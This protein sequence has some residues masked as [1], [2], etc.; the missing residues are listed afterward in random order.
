MKEIAKVSLQNEMDL[1]LSHRRS[2]KLA[3]LAGLS[4]SAQTT[5]AT[6]VSEVARDVIDNGIN[7]YLVL[8]IYTATPQKSVAA[9]IYDSRTNLSLQAPA[10]QNARKLVNR[11]QYTGTPEA[12]CI[13]MYYH[14]PTVVRQLDQK[15][16]EWQEQFN[17]DAPISPYDEIKRKNEQLQELADRLKASENQYRVLTNALPLIIFT[18]NRKGSIVYA[19]NWMHTY[20]GFTPDQINTANWKQ[21]LHPED[22]SS[23]YSLLGD[24]VT[25][26]AGNLK[27]QCRIREAHSGSYIWH[28]VFVAPLQEVHRPDDYFIGYIV[29]IHAQKEFEQASRDN[30]ELKATQQRLKE[31]ELEL[32][33][34]IHQLNRSNNDLEQFAYI[35]SHDLQEPVRKMIFYSDYFSKQYAHLTDNKG[36]IYLENMLQASHRMRNLINDLLSYSKIRKEVTSFE[37][38]SLQK[39]AGIALQDLELTIK[40]KQAKVTVDVLPVIEGDFSQL[41]QVFQNIV[42]NALK[43]SK[44]QEP[45]QLHIYPETDNTGMVHLHFKDNGIGF[46]TRYLPKMFT[47]FQ[48]LHG[49]DEYEGTGFGLAIC[50]KIVDLHNGVIDAVSEPGKGADFIVSLPET[51]N[52]KQ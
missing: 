14:L 12:S 41:T 38:V 4:L 49:K 28:Q 40:E 1:I 17:Y 7:G 15:I 2:M 43:Y 11:F 52:K 22:Y 19:N 47:L 35:A 51:Q 44:E 16:T 33:Q 39:A 13:E 42:S 23:F 45:L 29:D 24:I 8:G 6:A 48:R 27:L 21:V 20:T 46:D 31:N 32:T 30:T 37:Q 36:S 10:L 26:Q 50:K 3:E 5:F 9:Y 25:T 18:L 34:K